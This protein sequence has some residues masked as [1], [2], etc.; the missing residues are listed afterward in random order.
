MSEFILSIVLIPVES[1]KVGADVAEDGLDD[2]LG[3]GVAQSGLQPN[4]FH[5]VA[6]VT[7]DLGL[8]SK[9]LFYH[10]V[11]VS[12]DFT[13]KRNKLTRIRSYKMSVYLFVRRVGH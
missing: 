5:Q 11:V 1:L 7:T 13:M 12:Q 2:G 8:N 3:G 10:L 9:R 4:Q 6:S